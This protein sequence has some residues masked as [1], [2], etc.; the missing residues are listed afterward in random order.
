MDLIKKLHKRVADTIADVTSKLE[1]LKNKL[2]DLQK[3]MVH[4][5]NEQI[6][7]IV[8]KVLDEMQ[9]LRDKAESLGINVSGCIDD[10]ERDVKLI[11]GSIFVDTTRCITK[12][13]MKSLKILDDAMDATKSIMEQVNQLEEEYEDCEKA[14]CYLKMAA[15]ISKLF[16]SLPLT[17]TR[18][19]FKTQETCFLIELDITACVSEKGLKLQDDVEMTLNIVNKCVTDK[20]GEGNNNNKTIY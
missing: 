20:I 5:A 14:T 16:I 8:N 3:T 6:N 1:G 2:I 13:M 7:K 17:G 19:F 11:A 12:N 9:K 10:N 4:L 15:R 18:L